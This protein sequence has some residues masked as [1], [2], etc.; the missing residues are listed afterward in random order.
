MSRTP[1]RHGRH[2]LGQND[3]TD[4][5]V[6]RAIVDLA[7]EC[8]GPYLEWA[9]GRGAITVPLARLERP[10][11]VVELDPR[12]AAWLR[13]T[14]GPHVCVTEGDIVRHAPAES[15]RT[16]VANLPFHLTTP[17]LRHL[18]RQRHWQ[19]AVL[20]TQWEVARKR[21]GV[22][23]ATMLTAQW[24]PWIDARLMQRVPAQAFRPTPSVDGGI[25]LLSRRPEPMVSSADRRAYQDFVTRVFRGRGRTLREILTF[26]GVPKAAA[27]ELSA[28]HP[29]SLPRDLGP[30]AWREA[31]SS[32]RPPRAGRGAGGPD[33]RARRQ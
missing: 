28:R 20:V 22:G 23:G 6:I 29:R 30:E 1:H 21:A 13:R 31:F 15:T 17:A 11:Q 10:L 5:R 8:G 33:R 2:E 16:L 7:D 14:L 18:L 25:L 4:R 24:W 19:H 26:A 27:T 3:L 32:S 12:R 9:A